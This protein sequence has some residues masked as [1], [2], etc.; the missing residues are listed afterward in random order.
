MKVSRALP[1]KETIT[2]REISFDAG[3]LRLSGDAGGAPI[4]ESYRSALSAALGPET[5]VTVQ[6]ALGSAR[7]GDVRFTILVERG[8]QG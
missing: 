6:E 5:T 3:R 7:A 2:V 1:A 4:V 8:T